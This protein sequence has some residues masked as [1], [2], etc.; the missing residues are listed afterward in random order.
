[1]VMVVVVVGTKEGECDFEQSS[2]TEE[3]CDVISERACRDLSVC[4]LSLSQS[5]FSHSNHSVTRNQ[6]S[7]R[8][9]VNCVLTPNIFAFPVFGAIT[10][11]FPLFFPSNFRPDRLNSS[12]G[13]EKPP[14]SLAPFRSGS[15]CTVLYSMVRRPS[16][17]R[18]LSSFIPSSPRGMP[19][20][21]PC[22]ASE[23]PSRAIPLTPQQA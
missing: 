16:S 6:A 18:A 12:L 11:L 4:C 7:F 23:I 20:V 19:A 9:V 15:C 10:A 5:H 14:C 13:V 22:P 17:I 1:M 21:P 8:R 2:Y 3:E